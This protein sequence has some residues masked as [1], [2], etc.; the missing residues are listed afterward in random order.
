MQYEM[1]CANI[2]VSDKMTTGCVKP[3]GNKQRNQSVI[4]GNFKNRISNKLDALKPSK[5]CK[6]RLEKYS[7]MSKGSLLEEVASLSAK[8][9]QLYGGG[10]AAAENGT[11]SE[12][13]KFAIRWYCAR[14]CFMSASGEHAYKPLIWKLFGRLLNALLQ[15]HSDGRGE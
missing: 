1:A 4:D 15:H 5:A 12:T 10:F 11:Y 6:K 9:P 7:R 13:T 8:Q 2:Q 3:R 14:R